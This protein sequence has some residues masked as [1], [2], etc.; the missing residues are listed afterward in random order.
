MPIR[1]MFVLYNSPH[2]ASSVSLYMWL[3]MRLG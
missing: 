2:Y 1:F 3:Q